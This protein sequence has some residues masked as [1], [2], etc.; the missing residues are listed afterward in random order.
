MR[1]IIEDEYLASIYSRGSSVIGKPKFNKEIE[2]GFIK[3]VIQI[4]QSQNTNNL[5]MLKSLHFE[6][7]SGNLEGKNSIRINQAYRIIFRIEKDGNNNRVE[8]ICVE[9]L[10]NHYS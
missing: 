6:K 5:R 1:V 3:R 9:E 2:Q 4:E 7:L 10:N 8:I